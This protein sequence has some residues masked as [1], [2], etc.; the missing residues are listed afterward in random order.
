MS[1]PIE[2][3]VAAEVVRLEKAVAEKLGVPGN[4][5]MPRLA[6]ALERVAAALEGL[7]ELAR[8]CEEK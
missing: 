7:L 2:P 4:L 3:E 8:K 1:K 6:D 5:P